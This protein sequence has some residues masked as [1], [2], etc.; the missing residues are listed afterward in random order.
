MSLCV[1][2]GI[3]CVSVVWSLCMC[4]V[5]SVYVSVVACTCAFGVETV[6]LCV[7]R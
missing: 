4:G 2:C 3:L 7:V 1:W 6:S 5:E